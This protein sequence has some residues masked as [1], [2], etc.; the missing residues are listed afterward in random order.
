MPADATTGEWRTRRAVYSVVVSSGLSV[1]AL[2]SFVLQMTNKKTTL[3]D[4]S[5]YSVKSKLL[6]VHTFSAIGGWKV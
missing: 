2:L 1:I 6:R 3:V 4:F 5:E